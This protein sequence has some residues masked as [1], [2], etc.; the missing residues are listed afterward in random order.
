[1]VRTYSATR[2]RR[3]VGLVIAFLLVLSLQIYRLPA[4]GQEHL[5]GRR[6]QS[7]AAIA[8]THA[9]SAGTIQ[10]FNWQREDF[11]VLL[12][13]DEN[14]RAIRNLLSSAKVRIRMRLQN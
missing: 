4:E 14:E 10:R 9:T 13:A 7:S 11:E 12:G 8:P 3:R 1:M 5:R 6:T 2:L